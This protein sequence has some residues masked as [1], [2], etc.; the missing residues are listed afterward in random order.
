MFVMTPSRRRDFLKVVAAGGAAAAAHG[1]DSPQKP[2]VLVILTD[3]QGYGD[4]SCHGNPVLKTPNMDRLHS[5]SVRF[6]DFHSAPMCTPSRGQLMT[7]QDALRNGATSVTAGRAIIRRSLPTMADI[8]ASNGYRTG[9]FGK[10]HLGDNYPYRPMERGFQDATYF[11]GFG[12]SSA[13]EF[14]NDYF[15]GL[16]HR[17]GVPHRFEGYCTDFWYGEAMKWMDERRRKNER[18]FCYLPSNAVHAPTWVAEKYASLYRKPGLPAEF[19]GMCVNLDENLGKMHD[20]LEKTGLRDNT[21]VVFMSDNG[22][23]GGYKVWNAGM[24][25]RKTMLYD[26]GHRVPC[27]MSW[28]KGGFGTPRDIGGPAEM[29]DVL[30]T[31]IDLCGLRK[32]DNATFDGHSL[33]GFLRDGKTKTLPDRMLVVQYGQIP[34]KWDSCTIWGKYRLVRGEELYDIRS[35]PGQEKDLAKAQGDVVKKMRD[36]YEGWWGGIEPKLHDFCHISIGSKYENPT[37]LTCSDWL[38]VYC[39][40]PGHVSNAVGGPTGGPWNVL[41]EQDGDYEITIS[42]WPVHMNL[43]L[44]AARERQ[45]M[46]AGYLPEGKAMPIGGAKLSVAGQNFSVKTNPADRTAVFHAKLRRGDKTQLHAWFLDAEGK[47]LCGAFYGYVKRV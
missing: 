16:Y 25:G 31:V 27:F 38:D 10:W 21:V 14:D 41:V 45:K 39:D 44:T 40:N 32:P 46:T 28:P 12:M 33:A 15:N 36:H 2:N 6:T 26:G 22:A 37:R 5:E 9:I 29:Q 30:P 24:R 34:V 13:P 8:F 35:D 20:F 43:P 4:M 3:D 23:T 19:F 47:D 42:R 7:G 18:F 11:R 1:A 17:N